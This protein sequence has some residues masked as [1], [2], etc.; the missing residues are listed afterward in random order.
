MRRIVAASLRFRFLVVAMAAVL[1]FVGLEQVQH[2][3]VDVFPEFAPPKV[4]VQTLSVGLSPSEVEA[5]VT[6]PLEEVLNGVPGL[7]VIRSK[8]VPQL[9]SIELIFKPGTDVLHA[10][11]WVQERMA[12][13]TAGLPNW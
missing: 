11:Q 8:S 5:L 2:S 10:R 1:M 12:E 13:K 9:S 3:S 7:D 6:V 4:E